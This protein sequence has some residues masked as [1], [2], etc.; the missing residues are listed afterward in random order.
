MSQGPDGPEFDISSGATLGGDTIAT[1]TW[2][3]QQG[4]LT[5]APVTSV[6]GYTGA[7]TA[8]NLATALSLSNYATET[9]VTN[10]GYI[11][12]SGSCAYATS[13]GSANI[14][15]CGVTTS[16]THSLTDGDVIIY[17]SG[18]WYNYA[19][20]NIVSGYAT[21]T[22]VG[23]NYLALDSGGNIANGDYTLAIS[24]NGLTF[25][26]NGTTYGT[27]LLSQGPDGPEFD[28]SSSATLGGYTIA[29]QTWVEQNYLPLSG[30]TLT[31]STGL[32]IKNSANGE[33][34]TFTFSD[35]ASVLRLDFSSPSS[36]MYVDSDIEAIGDM[37][38]ANFVQQSDERIKD[39]INYD[40]LPSVEDIANAPAVRFKWNELANSKNTDDHVGSIAQY[41][42][43]IL[44]ETVREGK[45]GYLGMQYDTIALLSAISMARRIVALEKEIEELKKQI[46]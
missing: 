18:A 38:A 40:V 32:T 1:Q 3:G 45:Y 36:Y 7:V 23:Q 22:W 44:P 6:A 12:S 2:V 19:L 8:A 13:A 29:T 17:D 25:K 41:W 11:T 20:A 37:M 21:Q 24:E 43:P 14:L 39:V 42:Q 35:S 9:W 30:G 26:Y 10:Q 28:I 34:G 4:Y 31:G 46:N 27:I 15:G 16:G 5:S 33:S